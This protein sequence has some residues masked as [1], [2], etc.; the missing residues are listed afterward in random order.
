M[1][2]TIDSTWRKMKEDSKNAE[3]LP[4]G[5]GRLDAFLDGGFI[6]KELV[7]LGGFTGSGKSYLAGQWARNISKKGFKTI[8]FSLEISNETLLS[9]L[10]AQE[11]DI[12]ATRIMCDILTDEEKEKVA[13]AKGKLATSAPFLHITD[14]YYK[15]NELEDIIKKGEYEFVVIDF[16]QNVMTT[17]RDEYSSMTYVSLELQRIAKQCNCCILVLS[18]LSNSANKAEGLLEY[19]GSGGIAMVCDLGFFLVREKD[20]SNKAI[21]QLRKNRR[22]LYGDRALV[23][24]GEG[25]LMEE[26]Y[27]Q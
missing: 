21:L 1:I 5:F 11:S 8:Y 15:L 13:Q 4:T 14:C 26:Y 16:I 2:H 23:M 9:R 17:K 22:G 19:K 7:V 10:L 12:K 20:Q 18:Q 27:G 24:K 3:F 25:C 6:K